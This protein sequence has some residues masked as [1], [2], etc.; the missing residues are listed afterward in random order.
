MENPTGGQAE[1]LEQYR[2][3][4][5]LLARLQMRSS[6]QAKADASDVVQQTLVQAIRGLEGYRGKTEA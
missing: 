4:L 5:N 2:S 3:Y 6:V 1:Q